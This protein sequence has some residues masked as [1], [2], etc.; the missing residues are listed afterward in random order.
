MRRTFVP[1]A[2]RRANLTLGKASVLA[3]LMAMMI[4]ILSLLA[5]S[6][7]GT[8]NEKPTCEGSLQALVNA[9]G[10]G[11]VIETAAGCVYREQV[12]IDKPLTLKAGPGAEIRG[13]DAWTGWTKSG[14]HWLSK[15][16]VPDFPAGDV[17]CNPL[18]TNTSRCK[19]PE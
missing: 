8:A 3:I 13:S 1:F 5:A 10:P 7:A 17:F 11:T 15:G 14:S 18:E 12:T 19:W 2:S 16:S 6:V 4:G 9:A